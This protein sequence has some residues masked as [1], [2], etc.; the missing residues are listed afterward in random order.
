MAKDVSKTRRVGAAS[1]RATPAAKAKTRAKTGTAI[2]RPDWLGE[3]EV[4]PLFPFPWFQDHI[5]NLFEAS[6]P[7]RPA[8]RSEDLVALRI[9]TRNL[10]IVSG[11]PPR[12]QKSGQGSAYLILHFPPQSFAEETFFE[13]AAAP[14]DSEELR[15]PPI[16]ARIA[17]ESRLVFTVPNGFDIEYSLASVLAACR[18]LPL[19]VAANAKPRVAKP[20]RFHFEELLDRDLVRGLTV[21]RRAALASAAASTLRIGAAGGDIATVRAR[22]LSLGAGFSMEATL[23]GGVIIDPG[24]VIA[25]A[26]PAAPG[27]TTTSIEMPWRLILSP[28][29]GGRWRHTTDLVTSPTTQRT[30]LWHSRLVVPRADGTEI[31]PPY[32]DPGRTTRAIWALSGEGGEAMSPAMQGNWPDSDALPSDGPNPFLTTLSNFD[33]YQIPHLS[34]NFDVAGYSPEPL[35]T[36]MMMLTALGGWLDSRGAWDPPGLSVEEWVHRATMGR[37]HYVRV[38]YRGFLFPFGHRVALIKVSERKFH[39]GNPTKQVPGNVAYLRQR[40]FIVIREKE[41][42]YDEASYLNAQSSS[43]IRLARQFP[44]S[45]IKLLTE[46][47]PD[48]D[49]P[50]DSD[51]NNYGQKM[52]WPLVNKKPFRFQCAG[53]DL[54]GRRVLFD[55]PMIF[56]DNTLAAPRTRNPRTKKLDPQY[57]VAENAA[58]IAANAYR[59]A[60]PEYNS[61]PL[62]WQRV[63]LAPSLKSGDTSVQ[64]EQMEFGGFA[65]PGN[66]SLRTYS[67]RLTRPV[68]V[69]NMEEASGRIGPIAHLSGNQGAHRLVFNQQFLRAGFD[70]APSGNRGEIFVDVIAGT[71][72]NLDFSSQGDKSGGFMQPNIKPAALS[73]LAGPVM[74]DPAQFIQGKMPAGA[75]F[76]TSI[77]D[78]PLPLLFGCIPLGSII[79]AV[80]D[81]ADSPDK[82]PKFVSEASTKVESFINGLVRL[83]EFVSDIASQPAGIANAAMT[84]FKATLADLV[85][86]AQAYAAAQVQPVVAAADTVRDR[87]ED[88]ADKLAALVDKLLD[89]AAGSPDLASLPTSISS[90][91]GAVTDLRTAANATPGG[92][93][94]PAGFRQSALNAAQKLDALLADLEQLQ[95]LVT[96]GKTLWDALED[97]VGDPAALSAL[98]SDPAALRTKVE[99]LSDAI[100]PFRTALENFNLLSGAPRNAI[101]NALGVVEEILDGAEDLLRLVEM[102]T[103]DELTIRFDWNPEINNWSP[104]GST[105]PGDALF[106]ANDKRGL[107]VAVVA[108]VKK[109]GSSSPSISVTCGLKHF[110]LVLIAPASFIELNFEKIEFS[111]DSAAKMDVDVLLSDIK[112]V[113]PL[114]FVETL[115]DLIP[116]D[117]F[118]DPPYL[119]ITPQGIDAGFDISLPAITCG[120]LNLSNV[121]LGAGFTVPF[122]GQP[123]S[124]RFN[125]CRR[126][127]PFLLT[128]YIFGGG[129]FFGVTLDPSGVQILEASF[130]FGAAF[131][132]D[133]GVASG[134]VHVMAGIYYRME[135]DDAS[136]TGYFRLGGH[137]DVLGLITASIELYLELRYEFSSGKCVGKA[138]LTIEISVFI[139]SGSVTITCERKF[140]GSNGDPTLRQ[141]L[142]HAPDLP[143]AQ[144]LQQIGEDVEYAWRDHL[145]AFA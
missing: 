113:G 116:L 144:E 120:V 106:R 6:R 86:Q 124:V 69:P 130:E 20:G 19:K 77:S 13:Q 132:I 95:A 65:E 14:S 71:G 54:D 111:I 92:V 94:L 35:D 137:V 21:K 100:G 96:T 4:G 57:S 18:D 90:A 5:R 46:T 70:P 3:L 129:G 60:S 58:V 36:N 80:T 32:P 66:Q 99:A 25:P 131:S 7:G 37:D 52:F 44:F 145:E 10:D 63:A 84:A 72:P 136:L 134:G 89:E 42:T 34:S 142:G 59:A 50:G 107:L 48:I 119:D 45:R 114:S 138:Q 75:G 55:V 115:R 12:L 127:Q 81:L 2:L 40:M 26:R 139:F 121:S 61:A 123:L 112:F 17:N 98:L 103:G 109:N 97:I 102:L 133:F 9:E 118:S 43:G 78:L 126:D 47:T 28:H 135:G 68:W 82:V 76:P 27:A 143:L 141:M 8:I 24:I 91:R 39:N 74:S 38:V 64:V 67:D 62:D 88:V 15:P 56:V 85:A 83:F 101:V 110:D 140:A 104:T 105:A 49:M 53:T 87:V 128:V 30:E 125:F 79:E 16:R 22:Q 93:S 11:R 73:R 23:P 51:I 29:S 108:K 33:R 1:T 122:I 117:G 31:E 41:H